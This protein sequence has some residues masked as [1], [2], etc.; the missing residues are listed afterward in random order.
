ML[1]RTLTIVSNL[2]VVHLLVWLPMQRAPVSAP[3]GAMIAARRLPRL[4]CEVSV[5]P[6]R[7][8]GMS[9]I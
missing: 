9:L 6:P 7:S 8:H 5:A 2:C 4:S 3:A 1:S